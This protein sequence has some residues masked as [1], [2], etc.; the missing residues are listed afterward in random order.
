MSTRFY[1]RNVTATI[2]TESPP[3]PDQS[4]ALPSG[5]FYAGN[6]GTTAETRSLS[7]TKGASQTSIT[8]A[9]NASTS[10]ASGYV[11][12]F[13]SPHLPAQ[14]IDANT[15]TLA[16]CY[17]ESNANANAFVVPVVY[18]WRTANSSYVGAVLDSTAMLGNEWGATQTGQVI[19]FA[20]SSVALLANDILVLEVWYRKTS[21]G[22]ST[23]YDHILYFDGTT[24]VTDGQTSDAAS[25]LET[26]QD[27]NFS[28]APFPPW[29]PPVRTLLTM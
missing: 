12:R 7:L 28:F 19:T 14:T 9:G 2:N 5:S 26:P 13:S 21:Q 15:W 1:L 29:P 17:N 11:A 24:D 18:V 10:S 8:V 6:E 23:S 16:A 4:T 27:L 22:M 25:Y 20:G 3:T